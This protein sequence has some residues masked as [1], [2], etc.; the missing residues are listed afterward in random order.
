MVFILRNDVVSTMGYGFTDI[1]VSDNKL[2]SNDQSIYMKDVQQVWFSNNRIYSDSSSFSS[3][4]SPYLMIGVSHVELNREKIFN[5]VSNGIYIPD[6]NSF[7][8]ITN[9]RIVGAGQTGILVKSNGYHII[10][11][12][13][14][15]NCNT[16]GETVAY[17]YA[18]GITLSDADR[19]LVKGNFII[20]TRDITLHQYGIYSAFNMDSTIIQDNY[21]NTAALYEAGTGGINKLRL[22]NTTFTNWGYVTPT[23]ASTFTQIT[24]QKPSD[25]GEKIFAVQVVGT[26]I[27]VRI[28]TG[29]YFNGFRITHDAAVGT[30]SIFY[31]IMPPAG[32]N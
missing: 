12:N 21:V 24:L 29:N 15:I 11:D 23:A 7:V 19:C 25:S 10:R 4:A 6:G 5:P 9:C 20:D 18:S 27:N 1:T 8:T 26:D 13:Y 17:T 3:L 22:L 28:S 30:E 16:A 2:I 14:I 31:M 32:M